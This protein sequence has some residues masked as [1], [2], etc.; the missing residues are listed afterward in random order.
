MRRRLR[1]P[2]TFP[3]GLG[4]LPEENGDGA[5]LI[6]EDYHCGID[7]N[8]LTLQQHGIVLVL[9]RAFF[10]LPDGTRAASQTA[11]A[12]Y[13]LRDPLPGPASVVASDGTF[14]DRVRVTWA[15]VPNADR[16]DVFA[17]F[18]SNPPGS[19]AQPLNATPLT[20]TTYDHFP[21][22][23][24]G[25]VLYYFVRGRVDGFPTLFGGPDTG[26]AQVGSIPVIAS[27]GTDTEGIKLSWDPTPWKTPGLHV[28]Y[29]IYRSIDADL[30]HA[31]LIAQNEGTFINNYPA[32]VII[33]AAAREYLDQDVTPQQTYFYWVKGL[34][35]ADS[36]RLGDGESGF[37]A[38]P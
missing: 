36:S 21:G 5:V 4:Q 15:A 29:E 28:V 8:V 30:S 34:D 3:H 37:F 27:D 17:G 13:V 10:T 24:T 7:F 16:Y 33:R 9:A 23:G 25:D 1:V 6:C 19:F 32:G 14:T 26:Y 20:G 11:I 31:V 2:F 38:G 12:A 18:S 35:G 22:T